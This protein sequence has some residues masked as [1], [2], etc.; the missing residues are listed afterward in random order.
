MDKQHKILVVENDRTLSVALRDS[1][2]AQGYEVMVAVSGEEGLK[3]ARQEQPDLI[4]LDLMLEQLTGIDVLREI[5][6]DKGW[7]TQ[8]K[9]IVLSG[10]TYINDMEEMKELSTRF[11]PKSD[12]EMGALIDLIKKLLA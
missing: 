9:I 2:T 6:K 1:L 4:I 11:V 5:R 8:V 7:G 10:L 3:V 12:F